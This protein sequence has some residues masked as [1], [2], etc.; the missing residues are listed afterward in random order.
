MCVVI[1]ILYVESTCMTPSDSDIQLNG[2]KDMNRYS[3]VD[4]P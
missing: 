3:S 2:L 1:S 4:E